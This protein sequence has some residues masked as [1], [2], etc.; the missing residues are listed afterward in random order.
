MTK[1]ASR[2]LAFYCGDSVEPWGPRSLW[3]GIGGSEEAVIHMYRQLRVLGWRVDVYA[4]P[5]TGECQ[6][7]HDVLL[8]RIAAQRD[9]GLAAVD[10]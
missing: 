10:V 1:D 9:A 2:T 3:Q 7:Y 6:V 4:N 8:N 5:P